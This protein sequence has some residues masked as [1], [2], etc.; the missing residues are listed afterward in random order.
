VTALLI[1]ASAL[2]AWIVYLVWKHPTPT[3]FCIVIGAISGL[4]YGL[5]LVQLFVGPL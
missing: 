1:I 2:G 5:L 4:A 3:W